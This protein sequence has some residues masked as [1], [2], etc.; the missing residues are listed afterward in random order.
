MTP[1]RIRS[2]A[3]SQV[4]WCGRWKAID[5]LDAVALARGQ[6]GVGLAQVDRHRLLAQ[7]RLGSPRRRGDDHLGVLLVPRA[8]VDEV[9]AFGVQHLAKVG[10][11][12]VL[13]DAEELAEF[14]PRV[15]VGVGQ[16]AEGDRLIGRLPARLGHGRARWCR[17]AMIAVRYF[18]ISQSLRGKSTVRPVAL[19][20]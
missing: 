11:A 14:A 7:D 4:A 3:L 2:R 10:V 16:G 17:S 1:S 6:H 12:L 15:R 18:A 20:R 19:D 5:Q 9:W 8:D 13:R